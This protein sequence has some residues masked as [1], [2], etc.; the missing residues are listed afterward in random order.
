MISSAQFPSVVGCKYDWVAWVKDWNE[1]PAFLRKE[2][3]PDGVAPSLTVVR[4]N[5]T[6]ADK[7]LYI[8][9]GRRLDKNFLASLVLPAGMRALIYTNLE[10]KFS[11]SSFLGEKNDG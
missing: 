9:A 7:N 11:S 10:P 2:E 8:I 5:S 3:L 1:N 6:V 4:A